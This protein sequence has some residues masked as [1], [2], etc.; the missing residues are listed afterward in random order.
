MGARRLPTDGLRILLVSVLISSK[1][2]SQELK[3][4]SEAI[5]AMLMNNFFIFLRFKI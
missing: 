4:K 5:K 1:F 2:L 3:I